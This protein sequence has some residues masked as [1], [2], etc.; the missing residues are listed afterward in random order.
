MRRNAKERA[1]IAAGVETANIKI[2]MIIGHN[3]HICL[4]Q[5]PLAPAKTMQQTFALGKPG[6]VYVCSRGG[7]QLELFMQSDQSIRVLRLVQSMQ[8]I[9]VRVPVLEPVQAI[10]VSHIKPWVFE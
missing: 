10:I 2:P 1:M 5:L 7:E 8:P 6:R 3:Q 4:N 9:D